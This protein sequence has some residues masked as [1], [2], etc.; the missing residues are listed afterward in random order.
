[1]SRRRYIEDFCYDLNHKGIIL[2]IGNVDPDRLRYA[3]NTSV[4]NHVYRLDHA[5]LNDDP[6][7]KNYIYVENCDLQDLCYPVH[8]HIEEGYEVYILH[9][10]AGKYYVEDRW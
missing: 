6:T 7:L 5:L 9:E 4:V 8:E 1:M 2:Y 10:D 3:L